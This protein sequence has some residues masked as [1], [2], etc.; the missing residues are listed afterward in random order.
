MVKY[1]NRDTN[2]HSLWDTTLPEAAHNWSYSE[3]QQQLDRLPADAVEEIIYEGNPVK[4]GKETFELGTRVYQNTPEGTKISYDYI[5]DWAPIVE[6]QFLRGGL[7]LADLLNS[8][9]D[10]SY[11]PR[12]TIV[13]RH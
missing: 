1:F 13:N 11:T 6:M 2:L 4:W 7:R 10:E 9:F 12:N 3:W 8:L 5:A